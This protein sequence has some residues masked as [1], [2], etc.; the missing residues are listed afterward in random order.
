M[1]QG[2]RDLAA[3][4]RRRLHSKVL[5]NEEDNHGTQDIS[6]SPSGAELP[7]CAS[8]SLSSPRGPLRK[9]SSQ[10]RQINVSAAH[11][12]GGTAPSSPRSPV[13]MIRVVSHIRRISHSSRK[14]SH[15][16]NDRSLAPRIAELEAEVA[17]QR[18]LAERM[19]GAYQTCLASGADLQM[20]ACVAQQQLHAANGV[21]YEKNRQLVALEHR[22]AIHRKHVGS[23]EALIS[24]LEAENARL[25][26]ALHSAHTAVLSSTE[27]VAKGAQML[28]SLRNCSH[29]ER[30]LET[31]KKGLEAVAGV[32][33]GAMG[34]REMEEEEGGGDSDE[35]NEAASVALKRLGVELRSGTVQSAGRTAMIVST[36]AVKFAR[37][38]REHEAQMQVAIARCGF[39]RKALTLRTLLERRERS[40]MAQEEILSMAST[41]P[42]RRCKTT[43]QSTQTDTARTPAAT[44]T[45]APQTTMGVLRNS[46]GGR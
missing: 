34:E 8:S 45:L 11:E 28:H 13:G 29:V 44:T 27:D 4:K 23:K 20:K 19:G 22:N 33:E 7:L 6:P 14:N 9:P 31:S 46:F 10:G 39:S 26:G 1:P 30:V 25:R 37:S 5:L 3:E 35:G 16:G 17:K 24:D 18:S 12:A 15:H 36:A 32:L 2:L 41:A 40:A 42:R 38:K 21:L 43:S